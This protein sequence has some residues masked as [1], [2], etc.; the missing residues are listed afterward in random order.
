MKG[1][2]LPHNT[3][4]TMK[5]AQAQHVKFR[6]VSYAH[7]LLFKWS[8]TAAS[9]VFHLVGQFTGGEEGAFLAVGA[10]QVAAGTQV[11]EA[12]LQAEAEVILGTSSEEHPGSRGKWREY[13]VQ[14][15]HKAVVTR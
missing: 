14:R 15:Q 10:S 7:T 9:H 13:C 5:G 6:A 4:F 12:C 1:R 8:E 3:A 2:S 11:A